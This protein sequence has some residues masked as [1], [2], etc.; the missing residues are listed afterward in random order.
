[1]VALNEKG[2]PDFNLIQHGGEVVRKG[3]RLHVDNIVYYPFDILY[4]M[5]GA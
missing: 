3:P 5:A 2:L 4:L 1:M